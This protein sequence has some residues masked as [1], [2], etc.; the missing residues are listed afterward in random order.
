MLSEN[1]LGL[2]REMMQESIRSVVSDPA[3]FGL[4]WRKLPATVVDATD[5]TNVQ[6]TI[7]GDTLPVPAVSLIGGAV[8]GDRVMVDFVPP[9]GLFITGQSANS[10]SR[11]YRFLEVQHI[12]SDTVLAESDYAGVGLFDVEVEGAGGGGGGVASTAAGQCAIGGGGGAGAYA[13]SFYTAS[14][15][16]FPVTA[17]VGTGGTAGANTGGN[18]GTGNTSSFDVISCT[19]GAGGEGTTSS[20]SY[21][22]ITG[23]VGGTAT[24]GQINIRGSDAIN[25]IRNANGVFGSLGPGAASYLYGN[26]VRNAGTDAGSDGSDARVYGNG[27]AG[28]HNTP[29]QGT[30][31]TGGTGSQGIIRLTLYV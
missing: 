5:L 23:G 10:P 9:A 28:A 2:I 7:D 3:R 24:G 19:G 11:A 6:V 1:D 30:G 31:K 12:T 26:Q 21:G 18:G 27:G 16:T 29:S 20:A 17:V 8:A 13:R 14:Q 15:L 25:C 22:N 4:I